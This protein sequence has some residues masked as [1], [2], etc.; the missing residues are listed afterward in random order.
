[1]VRHSIDVDAAL[2]NSAL[3][4]L[5]AKVQKSLSEGQWAEVAGLDLDSSGHHPDASMLWLL[6]GA[7]CYQTGQFDLGKQC[8]ENCLAMGCDR[9]LVLHALIGGVHNNL[10]TAQAL[11]DNSASVLPHYQQSMAMSLREQTGAHHV[12]QRMLHEC[13][14]VQA[15]HAFQWTESVELLLAKARW[16]VANHGNFFED[17]SISSEVLAWVQHCLEATDLH[18]TVDSVRQDELRTAGEVTRLSFFLSLADALHQQRKDK[19]TALSYVQYGKR[20]MRTWT[21]PGACAVIKALTNLGHAALAAE[22]VTEMTLQGIGPILL[23]YSVRVAID[24][25]NKILHQTAGQKSEHGHDLLLSA[26]GKNITTYK[27][28]VAP[29]K[30][31]LIEIGTTREDLPSQ[32]S[33]RKIA[34]FC[35][36]HGIGFITVD[37]DPHNSLVAREMFA[38]MGLSHFQ[39]VTMKGE[40]YLRQYEGELDFVFLDAYDFDHGMHSEIRQSRYEQFLGARIDELQCHQMHLDC[41]HSVLAK[42]TPNGMVCVDDT[43]LDKGQWTAKGTL[44]M[45]FLLNHGFTL[46][47]ARNRAALLSLA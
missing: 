36:Q 9:E 14:A 34:L 2:E 20:Q 26:I 42:I 24:K 43:W 44:A 3:P 12:Q 15:S 46:L 37:M 29:R 25:A 41:A 22:F 32:G 10:G 6:K 18:A 1:M 31:V 19:M 8:I 33:T 38:E 13:T 21:A 39:A 7:A 16:Q 17:L 11:A 28:N 23:P 47:E 4:V 27:A 5:L 45:P 40:D 30:P 35:K